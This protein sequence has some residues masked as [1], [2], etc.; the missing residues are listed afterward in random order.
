[1]IW[2]KNYARMQL[3]IAGTFL[4][5]SLFM[6]LI[7]YIF[8]VRTIRERQIKL[9]ELE[10]ET[11]EM[12]VQL[13]FDDFTHIIEDVENQL[14]HYDIDDLEEYITLKQE[15]HINVASIYFGTIDNVM[16]NSTSFIPPEGFDLRTRI[17]YQMAVQNGEIIVTPAFLNATQDYIIST[18]AKPVYEDGQLQGVIGIDVRINSIDEHIESRVIGS[19]GY[20]LLLDSNNRFLTYPSHWELDSQLIDA[21]SVGIDLS[22]FDENIVHINQVFNKD[23]GAMIFTDVV[24]DYYTLVV[25]MPNGEYYQ[26]QRQFNNF[27]IVV[28][29][30]INVIGI[31]FIMFNRMFIA[32]P[33]RRLDREVAKIDVRHNKEFRI[34]YLAKDRFLDIKTTLNNALDVA[35]EYF[36]ESRLATNSL[37][38]ENQRF[39]LLIDSTQDF[40]IQI[41]PNH[42]IVS[43]YGKGLAKLH[44]E[45][46]DLI[47]K[48]MN[49]VF[50]KQIFK[51]D[52]V[53]RE[54]LL[55]AHKLYDWEIS[56]NHQYFVYETSV[57]PIY[58]QNDEIIGVVS[59]SRDITEAKKKQEEIKYI[60]QH[61]YLTNLY[62]R[63]TFRER[64]DEVSA[65][66]EYPISIMMLDLNGLKLINDAFGHL[67]GDEALVRVSHVLN[68]SLKNHFVARIG[69]DEFAAIVTRLSKHEVEEITNAIILEVSN[70]VIENV[71]LSISIGV[72]TI[73]SSSQDFN[74]VIKVAENNMYRHKITESMS[75][76]NNAI[77]AIHK[78]L[79]DKYKDERIHSEK[80]SQ[81]CYVIGLALELNGDSLKEL[82]LA[83]MYHDIGKI[84]IPDAILNKPG[85]L[86][87]EEYEIMKSHT[88]L[89]YNILRAADEYS[90]L[91]EYA[92]THHERWDGKGYPRG[93]KEEEIPLFA[94]IINLADSYDAMT[95]VRTYKAK[96][97][98]DETVIEII[99]HTGKQFD[100]FIAK[101]FVEKVLKRPWIEQKGE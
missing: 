40:I 24:L 95:S 31:S 1:M 98:K 79:T 86:T 81:L 8:A 14:E 71:H 55:G 10:L 60:N 67:K 19:T 54:A 85:K 11:T 41:N 28:F 62:N 9:L 88:E 17:W 96:M 49:E 16:Y 58:D 78:T 13:F 33:L 56:Y 64:F 76:R 97:T 87:H 29:I 73:T 25:F 48:T 80:V 6:F 83:G 100:P 65:N 66:E 4:I 2:L 94:R 72:E 92:L 93:L 46:E 47:G 22:A 42:H 37:H 7:I 99:K 45:E 34:P 43:A 35:E 21:A 70:L 44:I 36:D 20:A 30:L 5:I 3:Y 50:S 26:T 57:S 23:E 18:I 63:R 69:G 38:L 68:E 82:K 51:H 15:H 32:E 101:I 12:E 27:F 52:E 59:I 84:A 61:D 77:K 53:I 75:V 74:E 89:G 91:A 90:R 39:K